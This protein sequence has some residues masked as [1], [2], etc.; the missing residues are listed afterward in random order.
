VTSFL[1]QLPV[2]ESALVATGVYLGVCALIRAIP[3]RHAGSISPQDVIGAVIVGGIAVEGMVPPEAGPGDAAVM[4]VVVLFWNFALDWLGD[5]SPALRRLLRE[6]PTRLIHH[7][8][9]LYPAL[10]R[11]M[12]TEE[13]LLAELR[14]QGVGDVADVKYA[15]LEADGQVSVVPAKK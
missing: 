7:G 3:K 10:R 15:F 1:P 11:E 2:Y 6:P 9:I 13:E 14:K 12:L 4:I 5:R 8:R